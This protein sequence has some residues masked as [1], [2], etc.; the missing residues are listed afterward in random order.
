MDRYRNDFAMKTAIPKAPVAR[1]LICRFK[2]PPREE[3]NRFSISYFSIRHLRIYIPSKI[4]TSV[5][6]KFSI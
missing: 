3:T 5:I 4:W 2:T 6:V 1:M